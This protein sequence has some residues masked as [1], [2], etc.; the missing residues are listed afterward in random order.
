MMKM[1]LI[2]CPL[3]RSGESV[4][5]ALSSLQNKN[6]IFFQNK[7]EKLAHAANFKN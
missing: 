3:H 5:Q 2:C 1:L 6:P 4:E 7:D